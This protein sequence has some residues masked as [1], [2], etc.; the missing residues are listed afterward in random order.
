MALRDIFSLEAD[1]TTISGTKD[2]K[3]GVQISNPCYDPICHVQFVIAGSVIPPVLHPLSAKAVTKMQCVFFLSSC[4]DTVNAFV[5]PL[6]RSGQFY[7]PFGC[8]R[9]VIIEELIMPAGGNPKENMTSYDLDGARRV[10]RIDH[11]TLVGFNIKQKD[12]RPP[13]VGTSLLTI[14]N[15]QHLSI[16]RA[17]KS[18]APSWRYFSQFFLSQIV[19]INTGPGLVSPIPGRIITKKKEKASAQVFFGFEKGNARQDLG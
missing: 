10:S 6:A 11:S 15:G 1:I 3:I 2:M 8:L 4:V 17:H 16:I 5:L 18:A 13:Q 9:E 19:F 14:G 7:P 12:I